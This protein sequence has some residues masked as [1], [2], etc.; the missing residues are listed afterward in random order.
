[1]PVSLA[2]IATANASRY[3]QQLCKHWSH[4]FQ[5]TFDDRSG[6]VPFSDAAELTLTANGD[7]LSLKLDAS[8]DRLPTL[9]EVVAE[10]LKRFAFRE[11]LRIDWQPVG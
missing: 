4:K 2:D 6:K 5:V 11:E 9:E 3:L 7:V 1:M 10:H 8:A